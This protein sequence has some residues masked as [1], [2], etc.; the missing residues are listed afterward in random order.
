[1]L[2]GKGQVELLLNGDYCIMEFNS[3]VS[4]LLMI[5]LNLANQIIYLVKG[6]PHGGIPVMGTHA[7]NF[8]IDNNHDLVTY[9]G[10]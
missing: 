1:M 3:M 7:R 2:F 5:H 8:I 4:F 6:T 9:L 10:I